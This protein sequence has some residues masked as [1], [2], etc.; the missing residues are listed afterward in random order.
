MVA[1]P[2]PLWA[3][4]VFGGL[5]LA[6]LVLD[7]FVLLGDAREV[8]FKVALRLSVFW[9]AVSLAFGGSSD[10]WLAWRGSKRTSPPTCWRRASRWTTS[11]CSA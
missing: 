8:A 10:I 11:S 4:L 6:L 9:I 5:V 2:F 3:W 7:L 1:P